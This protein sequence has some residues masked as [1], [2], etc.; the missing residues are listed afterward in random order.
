MSEDELDIATR[1]AR[2]AA[3]RSRRD[4]P[5]IRL[6]RPSVTTLHPLSTDTTSVG[7]NGTLNKLAFSKHQTKINLKTLKMSLKPFTRE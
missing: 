4:N 1:I 2:P 7:N 6:Y 5:S 3:R